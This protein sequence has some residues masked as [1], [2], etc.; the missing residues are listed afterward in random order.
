MADPVTFT[1]LG[2]WAALEGIK[3]LY[4]QAAEVLKA[5]RERRA[6]KGDREQAAGQTLEVPVEDSAVL[7]G[8]P[9]SATV[10]TAVLAQEG[11]SLTSLTGK[12]SPYAQDLADLDLDDAELAEQAGQV[13]AILEAAY[14][15]RFT[16]RGEQR[17]PTG[18][19][20]RVSQVLGQVSGTVVGADA[21]VGP[22]GDVDVQQRVTAVE[23]GGS[24]TGFEGRVGP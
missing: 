3:F 22:G 1:V 24:V 4:G 12:L 2:S 20:V 6:A 13:R 7:D 21:E 11:A 9:D 19:R 18:T 15:Q 16:F 17:E 14:G 5:W 23:P 10:D 8:K